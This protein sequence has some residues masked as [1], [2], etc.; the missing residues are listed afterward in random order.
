MAVGWRQVT[1]RTGHADTVFPVELKSLFKKV[2]QDSSIGCVLCDLF[3]QTVQ[4]NNLTVE[5]AHT[6]VRCPLSSSQVYQYSSMKD[7]KF[8]SESIDIQV[9]LQYLLNS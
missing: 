3:D 7:P 8:T 5:S 4:L 1:L 2:A 6:V 9:K